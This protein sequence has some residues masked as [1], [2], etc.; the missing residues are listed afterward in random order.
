MNA[1]N[2]RSCGAP[3][4]WARSASTGSLMP[5]NPEPCAN[6]N[7]ILTEPADPG[8][9]LLWTVLT[10][11]ARAQPALGEPRYMSHFATCPR[12]GQHRR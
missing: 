10:A 3:I 5:I 11:A 4:V 1:S 8:A 7:I 6:G 9:P 2:C 12:A